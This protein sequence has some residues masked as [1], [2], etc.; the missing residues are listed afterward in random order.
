MIKK[1]NHRR[2]FVKPPYVALIEKKRDGGE[3]DKHEVRY[4]V[5]SILDG[6]LPDDQMAALAMAIYFK[7]MSAQETASLAEE[8][9]FS[10]D[11]VDLSSLALPKV[12]TYS[13]GG[14]GDK[15][16]MVLASIAAA[17]GVIFPGMIGEDESTEF[18]VLE[19]LSCI[20]N[21]KTKLDQN[22]FR[23]QLDEIGCAL[24]KQDSSIT[25]VDTILH[26]LRKRTGT[27]PSLPLIAGGILGK[28]LAQGAEGLVVDVKWG[29]GSYLKDLDQA[30]MLARTLT[31]V[32]RQMKRRC[33]ALITD[34]NQPLGYTVGT[35][36]ELE[37]A[38]C[39]LKG[40]GPEDL[41]K[42]ILKLGMEVVRLAGVAGS[43][44]LARQIVQ[45]C[46]Q[47]GTA[48]E[49]FKEMVVAQG[50]RADFIDQPEKL[51]VAKHIHR[52]PTPKRG[53]VHTINTTKI[54][55]GVKLLA[56]P[57][58][59][60]QYSGTAGISQIKKIGDHMKQNEPLM[61]IHYD[62][63]SCLEE[64]VECLRTAYR[65]APKRPNPMNLIVERIA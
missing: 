20:P 27:I 30:R 57:K 41:Q 38:I 24:V 29:N 37:E 34:M 25:P 26:K 4:I 54:A 39:L 36:L 65:L 52:L 17:C 43:T 58:D 63:A 8:L 16:A 18:G 42:L 5:D 50:G 1:A 47:E 55:E 48:L 35:A 61:M 64:A 31:R 53:Y 51:P 45:K 9:M 19:K 23:E 49:K 11:V 7:N 13:T 10:G 62:D 44:L 12:G 3:F 60:G 33:V 14:V 56:C 21:I 40:G 46:L 59:D 15:S 32:A 28:K 22:R 6:K 2:K